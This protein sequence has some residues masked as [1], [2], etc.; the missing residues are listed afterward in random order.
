MYWLAVAAL[1]ISGALSAVLSADHL[2][3]L[4]L[5]G[6]GLESACAQLAA[7]RW[8][9]LPGTDWPLSFAG[10]SWMLALLGAWLVAGR[11]AGRK[12]PTW[13][14]LVIRTGALVSLGLI[15][16]ML[17]EGLVCSYCL[18]VHVSHLAFCW[19][20]H[21]S[22]RTGG[23]SGPAISFA[24]VLVGSSAA[25][26]AWQSNI[27]RTFA[28]D[29]ERALAES[30]A[31][32]AA[33]PAAAPPNA[34]DNAESA[35]DAS[36][37]SGSPTKPLTPRRGR[38]RLG[39]DEA[40][41]RIVVFSDY[42]CAD[43]KRIHADLA[44]LAKNERRVSLA[45]MHFPMCADCNPR[46]AEKNLHPN[47]CWAARAA[48][49]AGMLG[50]SEAFWNTSRW[51]FEKGGSFQKAELRAFAAEQGLDA[52][53]FIATM[54]G[55]ETLERVQGDIDEGL[56][57]GLHFTPMVFIN[58]IELQGV[59]APQAVARAVRAVLESGV[60]PASSEGDRPLTAVQ[61]YVADWRRQPQRGTGPE[62]RNFVASPANARIEIVVWGD[63]QEVHTRT[64][65][66]ILRSW[67]G[68]RQ[69]VSYSFR[70]FPANSDCNSKMSRVMHPQACLAARAA[71]A[72]SLLGVET[73]YWQ[74]HGWLFDNR[75]RVD[76][77]RV[78]QAAGAF[79]FDPAAFEAAMASAEA[80]QA[81]DA[82]ARLGMSMLYRGS[83]PA[84]YINGRV[85]PRW[86]L[87]GHNVLES[88][89]GSL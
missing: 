86:R 43:C 39:P 49:A 5:P 50:G 66:S 31:R 2:G 64:A 51:L 87:E 18:G 59:L 26:M 11:V 1:L 85:V 44:A 38:Y 78:L 65:D 67:A 81:I 27:E 21:R 17:V 36:K 60:S 68:A 73:Q 35:P 28:E 32:I 84:I 75:D 70:H 9:R 25:L 19:I 42:Q 15:G 63:Y 82:E 23:G 88:I 16:L 80:Q 52:E 76:R 8:G 30:S 37:D 29:Q 20:A 47:A 83:I 53:A 14:I 34:T 56:R 61:K 62:R 71:E 13:L 72:A 40:T 69:D 41:A 12:V 3:S 77:T 79:G 46:F 22:P 7:S 55:P 58:G 24:V 57:R 33:A 48:E 74:M 54:E 10:L 4:S 45:A 6:C 89:L